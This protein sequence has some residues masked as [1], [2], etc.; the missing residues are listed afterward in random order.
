LLKNGKE[1]SIKRARFLNELIT[2]EEYSARIEKS[3]YLMAYPLTCEHCNDAISYVRA[4]KK[5]AFFRHSRGGH[6]HA[7]CPLYQSGTSSPQRECINELHETFLDEE[8]ISLNFE[9]SYKKNAWSSYVALPAFSEEKLVA[10]SRQQLRVEMEATDGSNHTS[11]S[12]RMGLEQFTPGQIQKYLLSGFPEQI[13]VFIRV[14]ELGTQDEIGGFEEEKSL[15]SPLIRYDES[16][17][18]ALQTG[19]TLKRNKGPV[20]I[21][22]HYVVFGRFFGGSPFSKTDASWREI[23]RSKGPKNT[24]MFDVVFN[25]I[26]DETSKFCS[27]CGCTLQDRYDLSILWPPLQSVGD[28]RVITYRLKE[29]GHVSPFHRWVFFAIENEADVLDITA[30]KSNEVTFPIV[31]RGHVAFYATGKEETE[32]NKAFGAFTKTTIDQLPKGRIGKKYLFK[33]GVLYSELT[34]PFQPKR[35][36]SVVDYQS[37]LFV[38]WYLANKENSVNEDPDASLKDAIL[39]SFT[40][41]EFTAADCAKYSALFKQDQYVLDYLQFCLS[42]HAIKTSALEVLERSSSHGD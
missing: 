20:Y 35:N 32:S 40:E 42:C 24:K 8:S 6:N 1:P 11:V 29:D 17:D 16:I 30:V 21:G 10:Y 5:V 12:R 31:T 18:Q 36:L 37:P 33:K 34:E 15:F 7:V 41:Q 13:S 38:T 2:I 22:K 27:D 39:Y 23:E 28:Y 3:P 14:R 26:T 4:G 9:L 19:I 25:A